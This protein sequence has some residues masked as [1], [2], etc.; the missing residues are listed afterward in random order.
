MIRSSGV[1]LET[2]R[3][4]LMRFI[5]GVKFYMEVSSETSDM[6]HLTL[7]IIC[8]CTSIIEILEVPNVQCCI[9][10]RRSI[11]H[12]QSLLGINVINNPTFII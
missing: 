10:I 3:V 2:G 7:K 5:A 9:M 4:F 6:V 12:Y 8:L 1:L 11:T